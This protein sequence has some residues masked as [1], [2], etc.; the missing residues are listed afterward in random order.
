MINEEKVKQLYKVALHEKEEEKRHRQMV[1]Y[2]RNDYIAKEMLKSIF[3][4]T[5]AYLF[6]ATLWLVGDW[7]NILERISEKEF[8]AVGMPLVLIYVVY[9]IV[10]MAITYI[11]YNTKYK[12]SSRSIKNYETELLHLSQMYEQEE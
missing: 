7:K 1:G 4:G 10:Y 12:E 2:Y 11:V 6:M 9:M 3:T 8:S 5:M